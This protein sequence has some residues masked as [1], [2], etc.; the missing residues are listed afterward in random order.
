MEHALTKVKYQCESCDQIFDRAQRLES[1]RS[2]EFCSTRCT[3]CKRKF[4]TRRDLLRHQK[5]PT[6]N[7]CD[8]CDE[9]FCQLIDYNHHQRTVHN[10]N[11]TTCEICSNEFP[12]RQALECHQKNP[13]YNDCNICDKKF[14]QLIDYNRH[15]Q[16]VHN[17][18][19]KQCNICC[20]EF[21]CFRDLK[22]HQKNPVYNDCALCGKK[23]CSDTDH[24]N[25]QIVVHHTNPR[26][27]I[28]CCKEFKA[29]SDL[30]KHRK[31]A[32]PR[33]CDE[34][35]MVFCQRKEL[36]Q[37]MMTKHY[38]GGVEEDPEYEDILKQMVYPPTGLENGDGYKEM[39]A[40]H[41]NMI[42]RTMLLL[43]RTFS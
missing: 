22:H 39:I 12:T 28:T 26:R 14:C 24:N 16:T 13:M 20:K 19:R 30:K 17:I 15:Q 7:S 6:Y 36:K 29:F 2:K 18:N 42:S 8:L 32:S 34:C 38:G 37:H 5:K 23:F 10:I 4:R 9:K 31:D 27:C 35:N 21:S 33:E 11:P 40:K 25:H 43:E 1:H 3:R 41:K